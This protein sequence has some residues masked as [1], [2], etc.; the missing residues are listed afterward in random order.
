VSESASESE[1]ATSA[2]ES[3][4]G[5][6]HHFS[7]LPQR[8]HFAI[9]DAGSLDC[10]C[11]FKPRPAAAHCAA[12]DNKRAWMPAP[13]A[14]GAEGRAQVACY[15]A[16]QERKCVAVFPARGFEAWHQCVLGCMKTCY[17]VK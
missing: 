5:S 8:L 10:S 9:G 6:T 17:K 7:G 13:E 15:E 11:T 4:S 16:C 2:S 12:A 1:S 3:A 14:Q